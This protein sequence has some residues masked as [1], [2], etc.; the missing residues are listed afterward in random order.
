MKSQE[1]ERYLIE[2]ELRPDAVYECEEGVKVE[3]CWGDWKHDHGRCR[4]LMGKIGYI[5]QTI[6]VTEEDGSDCFSAVHTY[7]TI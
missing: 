5:R 2:N 4:H 1:I 6:E 7:I 3:I